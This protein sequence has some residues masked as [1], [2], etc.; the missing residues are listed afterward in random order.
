MN[1]P[2]PLDNI[3]KEALVKPSF[4]EINETLLEFFVDK[5]G[6]LKEKAPTIN[7]SLK[8]KYFLISLRNYEKIKGPSYW[9][10]DS[11]RQAINLHTRFEIRAISGKEGLLVKGLYRPK[12]TTLEVLNSLIVEWIE[13]YL[14]KEGYPSISTFYNWQGNIQREIENRALKIGLKLEFEIYP[15]IE[16]QLEDIPANFDKIHL[17]IGDY[18][19][20]LEISVSS[21][22]A[23]LESH[24]MNAILQFKERNELVAYTK[25]LIIEFFSKEVFAKSFFL[26]LEEEVVEKCKVYVDRELKSRGRRLSKLT[27]G[28]AYQHDLSPI[29]IKTD[30]FPVRVKGFDNQILIGFETELKVIEEKDKIVNAILSLDKNVDLEKL[31]KKIISEYLSE[32]KVKI[33]YLITNF[34]DQLKLDLF[35]EIDTK[36]ESEGRK[37]SFL[38]L[39]ENFVK[40]IPSIPPV[41]EHAVQFKPKSINE[42]IT[43]HNNVQLTISDLSKVLSNKISNIENWVKFQL[44]DI[45]PRLFF[46][47]DY[48][49]LILDLCEDENKAQESHEKEIEK[50]LNTRA[51]AIGFKVSHYTGLPDESIKK[52]Q[53]GFHIT[54]EDEGMVNF[55]MKNNSQVSLDVDL[56]GRIPDLSQVKSHLNP[57]LDILTK[58]REAIFNSVKGVLIKYYPVAIYTKFDL[59][60]TELVEK[61]KKDVIHKFYIADS[62]IE[63]IPIETAIIKRLKELTK[64]IH[65]FSLEVIPAVQNAERVTYDVD[66][67]ILGPDTQ[68]ETSWITFEKRLYS[69]EEEEIGQ[70]KHVMRHTLNEILKKVPPKKMREQISF[71][72]PEIRERV[73]KPIVQEIRRSFGLDIQ[74]KIYP[75]SL[76][77][78]ISNVDFVEF[79]IEKENTLKKELWSKKIM[80]LRGRNRKASRTINGLFRE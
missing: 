36:I 64:K 7:F 39:Q 9:L 74:L 78:E 71:I 70:I 28:H 14:Q 37:L 66:F 79:T 72:S 35:K 33:D 21:S 65:T 23:I 59:V 4:N 40:L 54:L 17:R 32:N 5:E 80:R 38:T 45:I 62:H 48:V 24:K 51:L 75:Q 49:D 20:L 34:H 50:A 10:K 2:N 43:I 6:N 61:I 18:D 3:I 73:F 53:S 77:S 19:R 76:K 44:D 47:V 25:S 11:T 46:K 67:E 16:P 29:E 56:T 55:R 22:L 52:L 30:F 12:L 57:S 1:T 13:E 42:T 60:K 69:S 68:N 63:V 26:H 31:L 15:E 27:I 8:K 41:I 58:I